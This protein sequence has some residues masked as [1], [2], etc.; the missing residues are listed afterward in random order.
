MESNVNLCCEFN[1]SKIKQEHLLEKILFDSNVI[2]EELR[3]QLEVIQRL[4]NEKIDLS[5]HLRSVHREASLCKE[6]DELNI[7]RNAV[8]VRENRLLRTNVE[9]LVIK[10]IALKKNAEER[11]AALTSTHEDHLQDVRLAKEQLDIQLIVK[12]AKLRNSQKNYKSL[13]EKNRSLTPG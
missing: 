4:E 11:V 6:R 9:R 8:L 13:L 12:E 3:I 1:Q 7:K 2:A 5:Q 10:N